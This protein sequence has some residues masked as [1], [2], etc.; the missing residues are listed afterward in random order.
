MCG[1]LHRRRGGTGCCKA[2][3]DSLDY[4]CSDAADR[5]VRWQDLGCELLLQ[6]GEPGL[7]VPELA[8]EVGRDNYDR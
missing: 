4:L 2:M 1:H 8:L 7:P 6:A 5:P 3:V